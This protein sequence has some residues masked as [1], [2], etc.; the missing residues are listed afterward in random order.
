MLSVLRFAFGTRTSTV[1]PGREYDCNRDDDCDAWTHVYLSAEAQR[2]FIE[3]SP[4]ATRHA[5]S[6]APQTTLASALLWA[7]EAMKLLERA[8]LPRA[9]PAGD[10][11]DST[12]K[13]E[14]RTGCSR[15]LLA[16]KRIGRRVEAESPQLLLELF[17][18][19]ARRPARLRSSAHK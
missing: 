17:R 16:E 15:D 6:G 4:Q 7:D 13:S 10:V 2:Y 8:G 14:E 9:W 12:P 19:G 18:R 3:R 5:A 11:H 1:P